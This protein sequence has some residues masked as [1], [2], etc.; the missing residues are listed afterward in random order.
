MLPQNPCAPHDNDI[1]KQIL[2]SFQAFDGRP[3]LT[4]H[5]KELRLILGAIS[6][7]VRELKNEVEDVKW[8]MNRRYEEHEETEAQEDQSRSRVSQAFPTLD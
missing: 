7:V 4:Q 3:H 5:M 8:E 2:S 6:A 1:T